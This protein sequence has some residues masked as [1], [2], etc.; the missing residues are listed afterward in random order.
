MKLPRILVSIALMILSAEA[1][2]QAAPAG[3]QQVKLY[4]DTWGVPHIYADTLGNAAYAMGY[5]QAED[6]L[7]DVYRN[8]RTATGTMAEAF[9]PQYAEQDYIMR[10]V[11]NAERCEQ[12][13]KTAPAH[14]KEIG[15]RFMRG[16]EAYLK[17][18]PERKPE[19]ATELHGWQC[20][21]IGRAMI[22]NWPLETLMNELARKAQAPPFGSNSFAVS[23]SR[24]AEGCAIIMTDPHLTWEGMAVFHEARV[25]AARISDHNTGGAYDQCGFWLV[26]SPLPALGHSGQ[27]AWACTT[28][29][30]DTSDVYM[31][32]LNPKNPLQYEY[33][34]QWRDFEQTMISIAVKGQQ[35]Q[36]KPALYSIYGPVMAEPDLA[37]SV[38]Y[39]GASPYLEADGLFEQMYRMSTARSCEEFYDALSMRQ[40]MEQNT[41]FADTQGNI[42][43]VRNG[44]V[45]IRPEGYNWSVPVPGGT[46]ATRWLGFHD[47]R[48]LVQVKNPPQ[49]YFQ[50]CN[51]SPENMMKNSPMTP[52]KYKPYIYNVTWDFSTHRGE[53]LRE[54]L[55]A[56]DSVTKEEAMDYTLN[57]YDVLAKPWQRALKVA[58]DAAGSA[59]TADP[60]FTKAVKDIIE[61][62]GQF[63]KESVAAPLMK[64]WRLQCD[65][66]IPV[67]DIADNKP[68]SPAAQSKLLDLLA[69]A[70][71]EIKAKYG[72]L[73][74][75]WGDINLIGRGGKY[76]ACPGAE[77]GADNQKT[78]TETVMDVGVRENPA[79]SGK[80]VGHDGSSSILLSFL[81]K[82]GIESYSLLNWGQSSDPNSPHYVDQ[83]E[84]LYAERKFKPTW[85]KKDELMKNLESEKTLTIK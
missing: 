79:G 26:G 25:H 51:L 59:K 31:V 64:F 61:W 1:L 78:M 62:D 80:Y 9:G 81:H 70:L 37:K 41:T 23:P 53:R 24:S 36:Q 65:T 21:A 33:N 76:F 7:E 15:D 4:R 8:V 20:A 58:V 74:V 38:A 6:R 44:C 5:A 11:K 57:V 85:F 3:N 48:D 68:L 17:E 39:C 2:G 47:L 22:L 43:Y 69:K 54:L 82:N 55:D 50:N 18:H 40:M 32:K 14:L 34:G 29:G 13:W 71:A 63:S 52:D 28:G 42:Q 30:P 77:F 35:P 45:P 84:K 66:A 72:R 19:F 12:Y 46:D 83:A 49:G 10:L 75:T 27:V 73:G 16:I 67:A 56:D 60:E